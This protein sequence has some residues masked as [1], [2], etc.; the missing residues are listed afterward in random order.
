MIL[1]YKHGFTDANRNFQVRN[2]VRAIQQQMEILSM[3]KLMM[4][5]KDPRTGAAKK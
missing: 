5:L 3:Q 4:V 1:F 2:Y